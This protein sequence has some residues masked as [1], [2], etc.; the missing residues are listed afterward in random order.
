MAE[1]MDRKCQTKLQETNN[2]KRIQRP[3]PECNISSRLS[4]EMLVKA[5]IRFLH[6][7]SGVNQKQKSKH[8]NVPAL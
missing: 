6:H 8:E 4:K 5:E 3:I 2:Q 1:K 7:K